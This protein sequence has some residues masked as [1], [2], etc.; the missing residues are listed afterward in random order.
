MPATLPTVPAL[1]QRWEAIRGSGSDP[2]AWAFQLGD[3]ESGSWDAAGHAD[4]LNGSL[5]YSFLGLRPGGAPLF[6]EE[7]DGPDHPPADDSPD[8]YGSAYHPDLGSPD[9]NDP[10]GFSMASMV[11]TFPKPE[12]TAAVSFG[13]A[14]VGLVAYVLWPALKS[15][16]G[17]GAMGLF[18]R[19]GPDEVLDHPLRAQI[20]SLV[21]SEPG[22]H[23]QELARRLETG[24]GTLEHHLRKL[25]DANLVVPQSSRG[26]TCYFPKGKVDRHLM[27]AAPVLKS[28]GARQVLQAINSGPNRAA[29][30]I[31]ETTGFTP[32]TVNYHL[33][34]L[35][36]AG[37]VLSQRV[38]RFTLLAPTTL[39]QQ[40]LSTWSGT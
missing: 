3:G 10:R 5:S 16:P 19:I 30:D 8:S 29:Q 21:E 15:V 4:S 40:A 38:G 23:F 27:A 34:R 25:V 6:L 37:L 7:T 22:L 13:A 11:W 26:F 2:S 18:S 1:L 9:W 24:R 12:T 14:L 31:A 39:G 35:V 32:S 20:V 17:L 28:T 36:G 33:K